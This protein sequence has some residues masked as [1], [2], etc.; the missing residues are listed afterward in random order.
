V[1]EPEWARWTF[2]AALVGVTA[3][4]LI[5][6]V[7]IGGGSRPPGSPRR[8][9][10]I[11]QLIMGVAMIA[12][13]LSWTAVLPT[14]LWVILFGAQ[15]VGFGV[16]LLRRPAGRTEPGH[17]NW[18]YT[19]HVMGSVAMIYMIVALTGTAARAVV[20][21]AMPGMTSMAGMSMPGMVAT[22]ISPLATAFGIYFLFY[23]GWSVVRAVRVNGG[24]PVTVGAGS[25]AGTGAGPGGLPA[26]LARPVLVE[27]C[28]ALMGV[29]MAYLLL[30]S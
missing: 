22:T 24:V 3:T 5:R 29:T 15:A 19:H 10:D 21:P 12:M 11:S 9:E 8:H 25:G 7:S 4:C 16:L 17:Q 28:R 1:V 18:D 26:V 2:T 27:G 6:L 14:S 23:A 20:M 13:V 30:A